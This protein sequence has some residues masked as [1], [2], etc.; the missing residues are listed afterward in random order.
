MLKLIVQQYLKTHIPKETFLFVSSLRQGEVKKQILQGF[1]ECY[2]TIGHDDRIL[3]TTLLVW[4]CLF[5]LYQRESMHDYFLVSMPFTFSGMNCCFSSLNRLTHSFTK[6][7]STFFYTVC[8][9]TPT[10][11]LFFLSKRDCPLFV[12]KFTQ[13]QKVTILVF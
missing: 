13:Y 4:V 10:S 1:R 6:V 5:V 8:T 11:Q 3:K 2:S 12:Y 9:R 7:I